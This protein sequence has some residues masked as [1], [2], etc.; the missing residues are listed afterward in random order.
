MEYYILKN[1]QYEGPFTKDKLVANG[2]Q[3]DTKVWRQG[4]SAWTPASMMRELDEVFNVAPPPLKQALSSHVATAPPPPLPA[5][6]A[7]EK[8][9]EQELAESR[10]ELEEL[11]E[12]MVTLE[13][14]NAKPVVTEKATTP[15]KNNTAV[16]KKKESATDKKKD[17]TTE[18]KKST[19]KKEKTKYEFPVCTWLYETIF[20]I[21]CIGVHLWMGLAETTTKDPYV[22]IDFAGLAMCL[23]ALGIALYINKLNKI[24]YAKNTE[25]R[26]KADRLAYFNGLFVSTLAAIGFLIVLV[27][28]AHYVYVS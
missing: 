6:A 22:Y 2:L 21:A 23:V 15:K 7:R 19:K 28:S 8:A 3:P 13:S 26:I 16:D 11:K 1:G 20:L 18:K 9:M 4:M 24:S 10:K 5:D 27:Q 14:R 12:M 17:S 25:S